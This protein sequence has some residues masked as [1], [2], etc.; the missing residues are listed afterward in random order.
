M[1][2]CAKRHN[3]DFKS[4]QVKSSKVKS[5]IINNEF[6]FVQRATAQSKTGF[7]RGDDVPE[8]PPGYQAG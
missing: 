1:K 4:S 3:T 7:F 5:L 2:G 8:A 6:C